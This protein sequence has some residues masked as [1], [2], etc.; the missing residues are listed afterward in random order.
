MGCW[1]SPC[2]GPF[3]LEA[4]FETYEPI[5]YLIFHFLTETADTESMDTGARMYLFVILA[6]WKHFL[7]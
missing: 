5:I 7:L 1:I 2:Y 4:R 3:S 6:F